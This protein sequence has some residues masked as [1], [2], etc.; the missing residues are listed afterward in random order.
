M[1]PGKGIRGHQQ[2]QTVGDNK[3]AITT[4]LLSQNQN[5]DPVSEHRHEQQR[6][7]NYQQEIMSHVEGED[8]SEQ[9]NKARTTNLIR[10]IITLALKT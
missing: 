6:D 9:P 10:A 3:S 1:Y 5:H 7:H 2:Q 4:T 8:R